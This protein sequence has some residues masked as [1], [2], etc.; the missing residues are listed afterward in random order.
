MQENKI[1]L[2]KCRGKVADLEQFCM[3]RD[4]RSTMGI[5][6]TRWATHG[7]PNDQNAHPHLSEDGKLALIH[8][9]IV[10]NYVILKKELINRGYIFESDIDTE[11]LVH[12]IRDIYIR[13]K[14]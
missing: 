5:A 13:R 14:K 7:E 2:Y 4:I 9:G 3:N 6:H 10:E 8:N 12:L 11:V 1:S